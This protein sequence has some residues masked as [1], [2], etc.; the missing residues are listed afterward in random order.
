MKKNYRGINKVFVPSLK[1]AAAATL[2]AEQYFGGA[3]W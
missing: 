1:A 3:G 2:F